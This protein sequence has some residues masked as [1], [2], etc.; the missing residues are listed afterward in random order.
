VWGIG[1]ITGQAAPDATGEFVVPT[2]ITVLT[3]GTAARATDL[4]EI[5]ALS[6][7]E[8][9]RVP[10]TAN[11]SWVDADQLDALLPFL[12]A[13]PEASWAPVD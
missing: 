8:V 7:M 13:W 1:W 11:P 2:D 10:P 4:R 3:P 9:L 5:P 12:P 6:R